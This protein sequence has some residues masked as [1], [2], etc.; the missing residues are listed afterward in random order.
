M[1]ECVLHV[2]FGKTGS[3]A[4]QAYLC[5][6]PE[7]DTP[8]R[9][10]YVVVDNDGRL[11]DGEKLQAR[12]AASVHSYVASTPGLW[13]RPDLEAIGRD[14]DAV[15]RQGVPVLS[16]E[17]W[18]RRGRQCLDAFAL[19]RLRV[20]AQVVAYVRP[21]IEWFNSGWWQWWTWQ[22]EFEKPADIL[23]KWR[24][25]FLYWRRQ[26]DWW[27]RNPCVSRLTVRLYRRNT[28]A[29]FLQFLGAA[30][31]VQSGEG[32]VNASLAPLHLKILKS[33]P[34]LR[35]PH[36]SQFDAVLQRC[37]PSTEPP[38]W[39]LEPRVM[40]SIVEGCRRDNE[41]LIDL[42]SPQDADEMRR[43]ERW[44]SIAPYRDRAV[45][46]DDQ[47]QATPAELRRAVEALLRTAADRQC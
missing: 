9:H 5:R 47:L 20:R 17:D 18:G 4:L 43:D 38:P 33:V 11:L 6:H 8:P 39:A 28:I 7:L 23:A 44:W 30:G 27:A 3:S 46:T 1:V 25:R 36:T 10:R 34:H 35:G 42:L 2:G 31:E 29:D 40:Q 19:Q 13:E 22:E 26:L 32:V 14:L 45:T 41:R 12:A 37:L 24:T 21:Q 15:S 16:Q